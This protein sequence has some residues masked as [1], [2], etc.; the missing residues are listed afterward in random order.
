MRL[1]PLKSRRGFTLVEMLLVLSIVGI[2]AAMV[3]VFIR[4]PLAG[5]VD[6]SNRMALADA[7]D[8]ALRRMQR[9]IQRALPNSVRLQSSGSRRVIEFLPTVSGGRY[10]AELGT[11]PACNH[12]DFASAVT[13]F[14]Y[15]GGLPGFNAAQVAEVVVYNLG[16]SQADAYN[17]D[18]S[19]SFVSQTGA[20]L[21]FA[22]KQFPFA[23]P[24]NRF[25]LIAAPVSYICNPAVSGTNG[26]GTLTRVSGYSKQTTQSAT[27]D[28]LPSANSALVAGLVSACDFDYQQAATDQNGLL[29]IT[30]QMQKNGEK[31]NLSHVIQ[32]D[33]VP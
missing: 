17:S 20:T 12:L 8:T 2:I 25:H 26:S 1:M 16:I 6:T 3:A 23:S 28:S 32:I 33:N 11:T 30:I 5:V 7:A 29:V 27:P 14:D 13:S 19:A 18:N 4:I 22:S 21:T 9:E 15:L 31:V 24:G 10:C